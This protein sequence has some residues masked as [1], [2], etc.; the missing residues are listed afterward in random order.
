MPAVALLHFLTALATARTKMR[1]FSFSWSLAAEAIR[2]AMFSCK[3]SWLLVGL[4]ALCTVPP[5]FELRNRGRPTRVYV[6]HMALFVGLLV[7]GWAG[8]ESAGGDRPRR[9][10]PRFC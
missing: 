2:L 6:L 3:A 4:L 7:L 9:P 5:Y 1:R 8:V 10:G